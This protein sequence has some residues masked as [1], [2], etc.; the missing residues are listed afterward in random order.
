MQELAYTVY[1]FSGF[2]L[3]I[4][5]GSLT[6]GNDEVRLRPKSYAALKYL[7]ENSGRLISKDELV[8][9]VWPDTAVTDNSLVQCLKEVREAL[10]DHAQKFIKTV[11]RRGY[12]FEEKVTA[13][14]NGAT[15]REEIEEIRVVMEERQ[16]DD[17]P[18]RN[19]LR[20]YLNTPITKSHW[21]QLMAAAVVLIGT[22]IVFA[23]YRYSPNAASSIRTSGS[24]S[25]VRSIAVLPLRPLN[26]ESSDEYLELGMADALIT[27]LSGLKEMIVRPTSSIR[28]YSA[29]EQDAVAI[30]RQLKVESV[31]EGNVQKSG[32]RLRITVQLVNVTDGSP[33]WAGKFDEDLTDIF[34]VQDDVSDRVVD[35]LALQ[36]TSDERKSL[37]KRYT[38]NLEAY[39]L[40]LRGRYFWDKRSKNDLLK[41]IEYFNQ[42][43]AL[44][45]NYALAYAGLALCYGPL[46]YQG[47]ISPAEGRPKMIAA[48]SRALEL[49]DSLAE[50]H[51]AMGAAKAFYEWDWEPAEREFKRAIELNPS[52]PT[53]YQ[54]Y[55]LYLEAV[56]R[57]DENLA[58]RN[59][60]LDIDPLNLSINSGVGMVYYYMGQYDH[61]EEILQKTLELY[62]N[63]AQA[64]LY[65]GSTYVQKGMFDEAIAEFNKA[66]T[67]SG[68]LARA[69]AYAAHAYALSGKRKEAQKILE[70]LQALSKTEYV[71]PE[72]IA[73]V[74]IGLG[75]KERSLDW[76]EKAYEEGDPGLN[77]I[78]V[79]PQ[80]AGLHSE[81]RFQALLTRMR[82]SNQ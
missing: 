48:A 6:R 19:R 73:L 64:R 11:P 80:F 79:E 63:F 61:A 38:G 13:D 36:L 46:G 35:A 57:Q 51:A 2:T 77:H 65:L 68:S 76:L 49:D 18:A 5:R 24:V 25:T 16:T 47:Y 17:Q 58:A 31:L 45:P 52:Y 3:D 78:K 44:D 67:L 81:P 28:K 69:K 8:E 40:Y 7:V 60:A 41:A 9:A 30:G 66:L 14:T 59:R 20:K 74:Y 32:N 33:I 23:Y 34:R 21:F 10:N 37:A 56:G 53:S 1:S 55:G 39:R 26:A 22:A 42:A 29:E 70:G 82:L 72:D 43:I 75:D 54:W 4:A 12:I 71:S 15:Y 62:P 27:K 50:A